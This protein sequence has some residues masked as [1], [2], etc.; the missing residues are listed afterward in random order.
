LPKTANETKTVPVQQPTL[1]TST[2]PAPS[3]S[4]EK[5]EEMKS[6]EEK[7]EE[8][9]SD[10]KKAEEEVKSD[11]KKAE[12]KSEADKNEIHDYVAPLRKLRLKYV[13]TTTPRNIPPTGMC[14]L[15]LYLCIFFFFSFFLFLVS[16]CSFLGLPDLILYESVTVSGHE[17]SKFDSLKWDDEQYVFLAVVVRRSNRHHQFL[18]RARGEK[19]K[20]HAVEAYEIVRSGLGA[21]EKS[22]CEQALADWISG[23]EKKFAPRPLQQPAKSKRAVKPKSTPK[24]AA[25]NSK[26][27]RKQVQYRKKDYLYEGDEGMDDEDGER[28]EDSVSDDDSHE[29]KRHRKEKKSRGKRGRSDSGDTNTSNKQQ[30]TIQPPAYQQPAAPYPY[31]YPPYPYP[32]YPYMV[33]PPAQQNVS[34]GYRFDDEF[35][36]QCGHMR[37]KLKPSFVVSV[38]TRENRLSFFF[39]QHT[40]LLY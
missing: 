3:P 1:P 13:T 15:P 17:I 20:L 39:M 24:R 5:S 23:E 31:P 6:N 28:S 29:E 7:A 37:R 19:A 4:G 27:G 25:S 30:Q 34:H 2:A 14:S 38:V 40:V 21:K 32:P 33:P 9:K 35:C 10:A 18:V 11:E 12:E 8:V 16:S 26:K 36:T 22:E